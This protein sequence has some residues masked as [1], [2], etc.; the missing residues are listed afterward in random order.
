MNN[1]I[2]V[3]F[4]ITDSADSLDKF[5]NENMQ[6]VNE[7]YNSNYS[8]I[9]VYKDSIERFILSKHDLIAQ[10]NYDKSYNKSF[11]LML[12]DYSERLNSRSAI[13][14]IYY[15]L[16][17]NNITINS[18]LQAALLFLYPEPKT[19]SEFVDKF[20]VICEK[21]QL[22][23]ETEDDDD[24]KALATF[25]NYYSIVLNDT[26]VQFA[27]QVKAKLTNAIENETYPFLK[28]SCISEIIQLNLNDTD[29]SYVQLQSCIDS[30]LNKKDCVPTEIIVPE[31][32]ILIE[33]NTEYAKALTKV[34]ANF[35]SIRDIAV[36]RFNSF[37]KLERDRLFYKLK[38]GVEIISDT[39]LMDTYM[40]AL[41]N[42]HEANLQSAFESLLDSF[43]SKVNVIDWGCGQGIASMIFIEEYGTAVI[44]SITL[45]EPSEIALKRASLHIKKYNPTITLETVCKKLDDLIEQDIKKSTTDTTI[46]LFSNILDIDNYKQKY[47]IDLIETT[48]SNTNYF[49]CVSPYIDEIKTERLESFKRY[50]E[51]NYDSF[52]L[53]LDIQNSKNSNDSYWNCNNNYNNC[54]CFKH[55]KNGC[56]SQWT[57][58]IKVF[59][60]KFTNRQ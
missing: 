7:L 45:I 54:K 23:I 35:N 15:I 36:D 34:S 39:D 40:Y 50:F 33:E 55:S 18:R 12:L 9:V 30:I 25:L 49:V 1:L 31:V 47:L 28:H 44:K 38:R 13:P 21:L 56:Y 46:H 19:N 14:R 4:E 59:K 20:D 41:G 22:A 17:D 3:L 8:H 57:R 11:V 10:L 51:S 16:N 6:A 37:D 32:E 26:S 24:S 2:D 53:L 5:L 27:E 43:F 42:M 52:E 58:V 29:N 48:Q 60:T